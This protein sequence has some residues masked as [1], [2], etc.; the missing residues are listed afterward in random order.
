MNGIQRVRQ[1]IHHAPDAPIA[2]GELVLDLQFARDFMAWQ[3]NGDPPAELDDIDLRLSCCRALGLDLICLQAPTRKEFSV[4]LQA[5]HR[6]ADEGLFVFWIVDGVFQRAARQH[7]MM[8]LLTRIAQEP[9]V[10]EAEFTRLSDQVRSSM[11]QGIKAGAHGLILA[12]DIAY[13]QGTYTSPDFIQQHLFPFW[14]E[15][16][17][18]AGNQDAP[19]F[20][21]SDGNL[22]RV[23][24]LIL[25][26]GFDGLQGIESAAG[27]DIRALKARYGRSLCLMG[28]LEPSLLSPAGI[29]MVDGKAPTTLRREIADLI[30]SA[31]GD[32]GFIFGTSS[33]LH[34]GMMPERVA[35]AYRLSFALDAERLAARKG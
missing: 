3:A 20:F 31:A 30:A 7:G 32:G 5:I 11:V 12:D 34:A 25:A 23:L 17:M 35:L 2:R 13:K 6:L 33:G 10:V 18:L 27:M 1:V 19:L 14:K 9:D 16:V 15:H 26:A 8:A 28:G 4:P 22:G 29:P 24:P 21:H